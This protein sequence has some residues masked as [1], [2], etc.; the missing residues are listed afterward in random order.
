[1][2]FY[3]SIKFKMNLWSLVLIVVVLLLF[4][5]VSCI[6]L[7]QRV[8]NMSFDAVKLSTFN[9]EVIPTDSDGNT[10]VDNL[11]DLSYKRLFIYSVDKDLVQKIKSESSSPFEIN[12]PQGKFSFDQKAYITSDLEGQLDIWLYYRPV[13]DKPGFY[14]IL[15]VVQSKMP[16]VSVVSAYTRVLYIAIPITLVL[17]G[18]LGYFLIRWLLRP[19]DTIT[20]ALQ[21]FHEKDLGRKIEVRNTHDELDGLSAALNQTF[22]RLKES[23]DREK[24]FTSDASHEL[25]KPLAIMQ[26][27]ASLALT[28]ARSVDEYQQCLES[29][30][31]EI[32]HSSSV[33]NKLLFLTR[34]D[35]GKVQL[36]LTEVSLRET[37]EDVILVTQSFREEKG[38]SLQADLLEDFIVEGDEVK[39]RELFL[40]LVDNAI[41]YTPQGGKINLSL[42]AKLLAQRRNHQTSF[43]HYDPRGTQNSDVSGSDAVLSSSSLTLLPPAP[44]SFSPTP[45]KNGV[46]TSIPPSWIPASAG[47]GAMKSGIEQVA[48]ITISD[49]GVGIPEA[50]LPHIFERFYQVNNPE[51]SNSGSGLGL[52]ICKTIVDWHKGQITV[53]S[54]AGIGTTFTVALPVVSAVRSHIPDPFSH[55]GVDTPELSPG[56]GISG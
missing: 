15:A 16:A 47:M 8:S 1:M 11:P 52:T 54:Q 42:R 23:F 51:I 2:K 49:T 19:V 24:Q 14:D 55:N 27:E 12:K 26:S 39:L 10:Q 32:T 36:E 31:R 21:G 29:I 13:M 38:L 37:L 56:M 30:S 35:R 41:K 3:K 50:H 5:G 28:R 20:R 33:V 53:A 17:A 46:Q 25:R 48:I 9:I 34:A 7:A 40:N 4:S 44:S 6:L 18:L 22:E 43:R 45:L